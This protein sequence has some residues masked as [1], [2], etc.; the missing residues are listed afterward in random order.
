MARTVLGNSLFSND[1]P[2]GQLDAIHYWMGL[3]TSPGD[4]FTKDCL[5]DWAYLNGFTKNPLTPDSDLLL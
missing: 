3:Y 5:E 2:S 1:I 4:V